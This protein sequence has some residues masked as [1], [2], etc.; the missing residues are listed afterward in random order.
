VNQR[1][2]GESREDALARFKSER[3]SLVQ[4]GAVAMNDKDASLFTAREQRSLARRQTVTEPVRGG[5]AG[6]Q[7]A[8]IALP[9]VTI[10]LPPGS[11]A[12]Q[13]RKIETV[14]KNLNGQQARAIKVALGNGRG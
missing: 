7:A 6:G 10:N 13:V 3:K 2:K 11:D 5:T 4:S 12:D 14:V 9:P 8:V 1:R